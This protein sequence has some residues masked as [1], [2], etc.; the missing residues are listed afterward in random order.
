MGAFPQERAPR[1][2]AIKTRIYSKSQ[3]D[4]QIATSTGFGET[5]LTGES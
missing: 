3:V 1:L 4:P 2:R 5:G